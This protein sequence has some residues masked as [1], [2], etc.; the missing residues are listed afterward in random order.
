MTG[1]YSVLYMKRIFLIHSFVSG[2]LGCF[3]VLAIVSSAAVNVGVHVCFPI[4]IL[5]RSGMPEVSIMPGLYSLCVYGS[6]IHLD[7]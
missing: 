6:F 3:H 1:Q 2:Y 7:C 4:M 5:S